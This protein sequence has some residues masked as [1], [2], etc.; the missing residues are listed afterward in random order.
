MDWSDLAILA[1]SLLLV[2]L[3]MQLLQRL[4]PPSLRVPHNDVA[5]FI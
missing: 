4:N 2:A 1:G 3:A 5:G